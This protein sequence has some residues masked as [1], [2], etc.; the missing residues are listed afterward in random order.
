MFVD[1]EFWQEQRRFTLRHLRDLGFGRTS[2]ENMIAEEI[3]QLLDD[4]RTGAAS[5]PDGIVDFK[6]IFTVSITNVLW[7][8]VGGERFQRNDA[9]FIYLVNTI[10]TFF[11]GGNI[12]TAEVPVPA[13]FVKLFPVV[14]KVLGIRSNLFVTLQNF[15]KVKRF[16][17][18]RAIFTQ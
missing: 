17:Q 18:S 10:E 2:S 3:H 12:I 5:H 14:M 1:G 4:L 6:G 13:F 8:I 7:A 15:I 16:D 11:R 9:K